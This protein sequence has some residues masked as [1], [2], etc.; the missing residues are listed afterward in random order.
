MEE[1]EEKGNRGRGRSRNAKASRRS[2][3]SPSTRREPKWLPKRG[4]MDSRTADAEP[5][6]G[7][8][9]TGR[10]VMPREAEEEVGE[11]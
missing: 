10:R 2:P 7:A 6:V 3:S 4:A 1:E 5:E 8:V 9:V 11:E